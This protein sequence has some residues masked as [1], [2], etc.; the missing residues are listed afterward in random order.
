MRAPS[1]PSRSGVEEFPL[2]VGAL[3]EGRL[4]LD[5]VGAIAAR[6]AEGSDEHYATLAAV[7][8]VSQLR[9]AVRLKPRP[10]PEPEAE[11]EPHP[12][13]DADRC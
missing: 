1:P 10:R 9:T 8:S 11:A 7:A 12:D 5:Q 3:R 13:P 4:S 2:C 6:A